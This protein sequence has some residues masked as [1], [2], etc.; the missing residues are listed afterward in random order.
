[1]HVKILKT[2]NSFET[3]MT[4]SSQFDIDWSGC[5]LTGIVLRYVSLGNADLN[6]VQI[7]L[8]RI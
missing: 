4:I 5:D 3:Y 8:V 6:G 1:M 2:D 7:Y